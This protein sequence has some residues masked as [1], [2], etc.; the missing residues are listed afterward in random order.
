MSRPRRLQVFAVEPDTVQLSWGALTP[1]PLTVRAIAGVDGEVVAE[2]DIESDGAPGVALL[3]GLAPDTDHVVHV[4]E[5]RL[6]VRTPAPPPGRELYRFMTL[7][8]MHLGLAHFGLRNTMRERDI[9][10]L[11]TLRCTRAALAEG[12][13]WGAQ[14]LV[15]KGDLVNHGTSDEYD[16]L[17]KVLAEAGLPTEAIPGNHEV[18]PH[19][20]IDHDEAF[21]RLG[22]TVPDEG[23]HTVDF[24]GLR[25][26]L[27]DSTMDGVNTPRLDHV[28]PHL[29]EAIDRRPA[30]VLLH[31]H[32]L[33]LPVSTYW[34]P[35]VPSPLAGRFLRSVAAA[36][37][38]VVVAS[39][40]THR[41]RMR[42]VGPVVV[43]ENG[44]PKDYPGTWTGYVVHEGGLRQVTRRVARPDAIG[45]TEHSRRAALGVW[46]KWSPGTLDQR[47]FTIPWAV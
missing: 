39:G 8:D 24:P 5:H 10:E 17:G 27:V 43:T 3:A 20:E 28:I 26:A 7:S 16:L 30:L 33:R 2:Q 37:P 25:L 19:R 44:S 1:G 41:H 22:L 4:G 13:A 11:H 45:W 12:K 23:L 46:G 42:R 35:G 14:H 21:T 15:L 6:A 18:K 34:P 38:N 29:G 40:H 9:E 32:L 47:C 36:S 31:H